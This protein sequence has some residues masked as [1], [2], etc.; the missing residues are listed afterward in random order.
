M[1]GGLL[2]VAGRVRFGRLGERFSHALVETVVG[3]VGAEGA[4]LTVPDPKW[5]GLFDLD[6]PE[7]DLPGLDVAL[8][9]ELQGERRGEQREGRHDG[10]PLVALVLGSAD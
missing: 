4:V 6:D 2:V 1:L 5:G 10:R 7:L 3:Q 9:D 8:A